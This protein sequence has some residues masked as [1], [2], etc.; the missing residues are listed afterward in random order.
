[1]NELD[2]LIVGAG[3]SGISAAC[4]LKMHCPQKEFLLLEGRESL[5]GTW[6]LFRYPG[7]RSDSD[8]HTFGFSFKPWT[9]PKTL[10][11]GPS[12]LSYLEETVDEYELRPHLQFGKQVHAANW[13]SARRRWLLRVTDIES[14]EEQTYTSKLLFMCSGYY[15]YAN[16]YTPD[17]PGMDEFKGAAIHPQHWPEDLDYRGKKVAVIGSGATAVTLVPAMADDAASVTMIQ[18]SPT[19]VI[20]Q[21]EKDWIANTLRAVLPEQWAYDLT[22]WKN[23]RLQNFIYSRSRKKPHKLK[24][25]ILGLLKK[26]LDEETVEEHFTPGY[27]PWDQ[28]LC[29]VPDADLFQALNSGKARVVTD[30]IDRITPTGVRLKSGTEVEADILVTATGLNL[31]LLGGVEFSLDDRPVDFAETQS[32]HGMM[33]AGVPNML[34]TFGYINASWTL[35]ADLNSLFACELMKKMD[36]LEAEQV[37]PQISDSD[38][39]LATEPWISDFSAGYMARS[40]HLFPKQGPNVPW[41]NTQNYLLDKKLLRTGRPEDGA[42]QF[43]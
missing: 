39:K 38:R 12:I 33:Y 7:I 5:G 26:H 20:T 27:N 3:V 16:G 36:E 23:I 10:A 19:Y 18:R 42:L 30:Q 2:L 28:R 37:V 22:R 25:Q 14:G 35:R 8:M 15:Q 9:D 34:Q 11:D 4:H 24:K 41:R 6:D 40:L 29:L 32:Y 31:Q 1:M 17:F 21:P 13:D 43:S